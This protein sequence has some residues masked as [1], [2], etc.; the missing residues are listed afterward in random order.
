MKIVRAVVWAGAFCVV[1]AGLGI[2]QTSLRVD[3]KQAKEEIK[4]IKSRIKDWGLPSEYYRIADEKALEDVI[5][6]IND[7]VDRF[8]SIKYLDNHQLWNYIGMYDYVL[9]GTKGTGT[10][11]F[12]EHLRKMVIP[13]DAMKVRLVTYLMHDSQPDGVYGEL[14]VD[15]YTK[16]FGDYPV[17]FVNDLKTR[18]DW[19]NVIDDL[20]AGDYVAMTTGLEKL[21]NSRFEMDLKEYWKEGMKRWR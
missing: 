10:F 1:S 7:P 20:A 12:F 14:M 18:S 6:F 19:K 21:G 16:L 11:Y 13:V 8:D 4:T 17:L 9:K 3:R 2:A 5:L 15:L